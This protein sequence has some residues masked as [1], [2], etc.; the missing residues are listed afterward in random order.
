MTGDLVDLLRRVSL[1]ASMTDAAYA[2]VAS[3]TE[4]HA[5]A[6]GDTITHEGGRGD[7][8][9]VI[10]SGRAEVR[11]GGEQVASLGPGDFF[12]EIALI[13]GRPRTASVIAS[14]D[15]ILLRIERNAFLRIVDEQPA[16]RHGV[17][18]ALTRRIRNDAPSPR[19]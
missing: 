15:L 7:A 14:N 3:L 9:Y 8:F 4:S 11:R 13:D 1:F 12:G 10:A 2:H 5:V 18:M 16:T 6:T 17:L 19:D